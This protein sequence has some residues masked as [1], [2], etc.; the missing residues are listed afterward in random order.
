MKTEQA[1]IMYIVVEDESNIL[2]EVFNK[3]FEQ[4]EKEINKWIRQI[5]IDIY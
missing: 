3:F 4:I 5:G 1:T 2:D